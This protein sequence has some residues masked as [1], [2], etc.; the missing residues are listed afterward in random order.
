MCGGDDIGRPKKSVASGRRLCVDP[1]V[2]SKP[3]A[4]CVRS[5]E[6]P[7]LMSGESGEPM[8]ALAT[9]VARL[10]RS[11]GSVTVACAS[12]AGAVTP[13]P[14]YE[15]LLKLTPGK[16]ARNADPATSERMLKNTLLKT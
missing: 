2:A 6:R 4:S 7:A 1:P 13:G 5:T 12:A 14:K 9:S 11:S 8:V 15:L 10:P 3:G 16:T